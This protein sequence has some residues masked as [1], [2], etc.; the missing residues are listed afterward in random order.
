MMSFIM[1]SFVKGKASSCTTSNN[2]IFIRLSYFLFS[3]DSQS[4]IGINSSASLRIIAY[5]LSRAILCCLEYHKLFWYIRR[6]WF[7]SCQKKLLGVCM[8]S[9]TNTSSNTTPQGCMREYLFFVRVVAPTFWRMG[10]KNTLGA[11]SSK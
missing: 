10:N 4:F 6:A 5:N 7:K 1:L 8:S 9:S 3:G 2:N 11:L